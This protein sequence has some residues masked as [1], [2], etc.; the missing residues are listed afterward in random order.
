MAP[1][2]PASKCMVCHGPVLGSSA[3]HGGQTMLLLVKRELALSP[4]QELP[5]QLLLQLVLCTSAG[6]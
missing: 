4:P 6:L 1:E 2:S 3:W 5:Q